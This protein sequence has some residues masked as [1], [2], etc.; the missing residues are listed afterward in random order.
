LWSLLA[1]VLFST[2]LIEG[3]RTAVQ[4]WTS[5]SPFIAEYNEMEMGVQ[6]RGLNSLADAMDDEL[7]VRG[8]FLLWGIIGQ[9]KPNAKK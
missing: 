4:F 1:A 9:R 6:R 7:P 8:T 3:C 2:F 5:V